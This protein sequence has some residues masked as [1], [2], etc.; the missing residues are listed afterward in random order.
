MR[1]TLRE[2]PTEIERQSDTRVYFDSGGEG[3]RERDIGP[4][5]SGKKYF[6][7]SV[8]ILLYEKKLK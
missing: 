3:E 5:C 1:E 7:S 2:L 8:F 4:V 6:S